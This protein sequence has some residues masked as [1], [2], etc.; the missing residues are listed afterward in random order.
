MCVDDLC[1]YYSP[2]LF[3]MSFY[4]FCSWNSISIDVYTILYRS[5]ILSSLV[6]QVYR[7]ER[8]FGASEILPPGCR[9]QGPCSGISRGEGFQG[10]DH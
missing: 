9:S 3:R 4:A 8:R 2:L 1:G 10:F 6:L 7:D 5:D